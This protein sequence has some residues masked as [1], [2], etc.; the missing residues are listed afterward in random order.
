ML[1]VPTVGAVH[2]L[3]RITVIAVAAIVLLA[4]PEAF[5]A[6][7]SVDPSFGSGGHTTVQANA[8]CLRGCVEFGGSYAE[9]LMLQPNGGI[10]LAGSDNYIGAGVSAGRPAGALVQLEADGTLDASF[11]GEGHIENAPFDISHIFSAGGELVALGSNEAQKIGVEHYS[12]GVLNRSFGSDGVL[13]I[14]APDGLVD[15]TLDSTGRIVVLAGEHTGKIEIARFLAS[16]SPDLSFGHDGIVWMPIASEAEPVTATT[17]SNGD[18][19]VAGATYKENALR[20]VTKKKLVLARL[21]PS[22]KLDHSFGEDGIVHVPLVHPG[23]AKLAIAP[24]RHITLATTS[25]PKGAIGE[26]ELILANYTSA[27]ALNRSFGKDG[28]TRSVFAS[29]RREGLGPRAI[30]F[31]AMGDTLV[32][33]ERPTST[34][35][36]PAGVAFLARYTPN[37]RDCS[38]GSSGVVIDSEIGGANAVAVQPDGHIVIAG[39]SKKSFAAARYIGGGTPHT[40]Q[41]EPSHSKPI[42]QLP[43]LRRR[44]SPV[45]RGDGEAWRSMA[46]PLP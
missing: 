14:A 2:N 17:Q 5:A 42:H 31:D 45:R 24:D 33:G 32:V 10:L 46:L 27:G 9:A 22:G 16:G 28:I 21:T 20:E 19:V 23:R 40:C 34:V 38:F 43:R 37:G 4:A 39:W 25:S 18:I 7:G 26:S 1:S 12:N 6:P 13:W 11:G 3:H 15:E 30:A 36:V 8:A 41:G 35:D 29:N 44:R